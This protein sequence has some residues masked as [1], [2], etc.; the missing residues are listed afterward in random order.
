MLEPVNIVNYYPKPGPT[1]GKLIR[2][3]VGLFKKAG[4]SLPISKTIFLSVSGG[5][6]SL[7]MAHLLIRYGRK[8]ASAKQFQ[9][10]HINHHWRAEQSDDE[11]LLV[12]RF[13]KKVGAECHVFHLD[14]KHLKKGLSPEDAARK[15]RRKIFDD[16]VHRFPGAWIF[17]AHH[18]DDLAE[19][20]IWRA[21]TGQL[22]THAGGILFQNGSI[23][24]PLLT[25][26]KSE[27]IQYLKEEKLEYRI[28]PTNEDVRFLRGKIRKFLVPNLD[29]CFPA[30]VNRVTEYALSAQGLGEPYELKKIQAQVAKQ[31]LGSRRSQIHSRAKEIYERKIKKQ[32]T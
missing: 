16:I 30:W 4:I 18:L 17:T 15:E 7:A 12:E 1:G 6:D 2:K 28:D 23:L 21:C 32:K 20:W 11:M 19:T 29:L 10:I 9:I 5:P 8:I 14:P 22:E 3:V 31:F 26:R 25:A 24:R 13:A 27:L